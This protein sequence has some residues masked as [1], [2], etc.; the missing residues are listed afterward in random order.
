MAALD[1]AVIAEAIQATIKA[2]IDTDRVNVY[3]FPEGVAE[4]PYI[5]V[6]PG[7]PFVAYQRTFGTD[8]LAEIQFE[9]EINTGVPAGSG[10]TYRLMYEMLG[11]GAGATVSIFDALAADPTLGGAVG[12]SAALDVARPELDEGTGDLVASFPIT[13]YQQRGTL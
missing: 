13:V 10:D 4:R 5:V 12:N 1:L 11:Q 2:G 3:A 8:G 9:L 6:R 7:S